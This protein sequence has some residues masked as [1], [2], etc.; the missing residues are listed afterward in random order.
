MAAHTSDNVGLLENLSICNLVMQTLYLPTSA[1]AICRMDYAFINVNDPLL[2]GKEL[3]E[4][5]SC[6]LSLKP[7]IIIVMSIYNWL[8]SSVRNI[9]LLVKGS[10]ES[11]TY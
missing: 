4:H 1:P 9:Q 10:E 11:L 6:I 3:D 7:C 8:H 2:L 5:C